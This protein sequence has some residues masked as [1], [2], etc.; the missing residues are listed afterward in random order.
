[1]AGRSKRN[2]VLGLDLGSYAVKAVE[3]V[4]DGEGLLV[5][6]YAYE[7]VLDPDDYA[8]AIRAA[9]RADG[10][11]AER[12]AVAVSGRGTIVETVSTPAAGEDDLARTL[13]DAVEKSIRQDLSGAVFDYDILDAGDP[14]EIDAVLAAAAKEELDARLALLADADLEADAA[15]VEL[16]ALANAFDTANLDGELLESR[17]GAVLIDIG[18]VKTLVA[19][20]DTDVHLFRELPQGG[21]GLTDL[22]ARRLGIDLD[23]AE[24][25]KCDPGDLMETVK[26]AIYPG[27]EELAAEIRAAVDCFA[28]RG[29]EPS[30][31]FVSGGF[32]AFPGAVKALGRLVRLETRVFDTFGG[33]ECVAADKN[34]FAEYAHVFPVA[35]GLA[36]RA[37]L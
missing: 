11:L 30:R 1:M 20:S 13:R 10:I 9:V 35:F 18:A 14:A 32:A 36:S 16:I 17:R 4:R 37:R 21:A 22:V 12:I 3:M 27:I 25:V 6:G 26:D 23:E 28:M 7:P 19:A 29:G 31:L 2:R 5:T 24:R 34:F 15:D 8:R 33:V